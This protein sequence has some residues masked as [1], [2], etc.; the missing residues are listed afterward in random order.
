MNADNLLETIE[1]AI[2]PGA[3]WDEPD[4]GTDEWIGWK[5][6]GWIRDQYLAAAHRVIAALGLTEEHRDEFVG[7]GFITPSADRWV[8]PWQ[9]EE[10][11]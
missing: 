7:H 6:Q 11:K 2:D 10:E 9:E 1:R 5:E 4:E 8:T 3:W